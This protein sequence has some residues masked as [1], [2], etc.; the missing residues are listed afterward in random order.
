MV[1]GLKL[2]FEGREKNVYMHL[3]D[4]TSNRVAITALKEKN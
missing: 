4:Q 2:K 1:Q 3:S